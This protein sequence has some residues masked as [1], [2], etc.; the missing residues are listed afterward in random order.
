MKGSSGVDGQ[1]SYLGIKSGL[2]DLLH[3]NPVSNE[4]PVLLQFN[5][6]GLPLF[7][8]SNIEMWPILCLSK[9]IS[10]KP[11]VEAIYCGVKKLHPLS[12]FLNNFVNEL[13][14]LLAEGVVCGGVQYEVK[15]DCFVCDAPARA[16]VKNV[17]SHTGYSGCEKCKEDGV[18]MSKHMTFPGTDAVLRTDDEV[19][20][21]TDEMHHNG[22][23]PLSKLP[24]CLVSQFVYDYMHLVCLGVVRKLLKFWLRGPIKKNDSVASRL[25]ARNVQLLSDKLVKLYKY[26][27]SEFARKPRSVSEVDRWKATEFRQFLLYTGPVILPGILSQ[28]VYNHFLLLSVAIT[29]LVSSDL[30]QKYA[31]YAHSLLVLFVEQAKQVYGDDF[32]VYNVHGLTHLAADIKHHGSLDG[33]SAFP[34]E[35]KLKALK[36]LVRK[37]GCP[38]S[39]VVRRLSEERTPFSESRC[40]DTDGTPVCEAEHNDGPVPDGYEGARQFVCLNSIN[41][42][43][44][45]LNVKRTGDRCVLVQDVGPVL[46]V[47]IL[48]LTGIV[49]VVFKQFK[50]VMDLFDSPLPSSCL[51]IYKVSMTSKRLSV[52]R[53]DRVQTKCVLMPL[54]ADDEKMAYAVV[55]VIHTVAVERS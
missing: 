25:C 9:V 7:K 18:Y 36:I 44:Y 10:S 14:S 11:F 3:D 21:M 1:F 12:D 39:Q 45:R 13:Q 55:P 29:L 24:I 27:P 20:N 5:F 54:N 19:R 50:Q 22:P 23:T 16:F 6:D 38:L 42:C 26:I 8:S 52:C 28:V 30:C 49:Y 15:V 2:L 43:S 34:F 37:P 41:S 33:C 53:V 4:K 48:S 47:N 46:A 40:L 51:G 35:N 32:I 17:K 31:E